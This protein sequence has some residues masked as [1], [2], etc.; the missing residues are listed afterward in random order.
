M[1]GRRIG[2]TRRRK[3]GVRRD[4]RIGGRRRVARARMAPE[5]VMQ[6]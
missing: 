5:A 6:A 4:D 3:V 1:G 2:N